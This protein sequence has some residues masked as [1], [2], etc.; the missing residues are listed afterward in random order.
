VEMD[1]E[2]LPRKVQVDS[3][4]TLKIINHSKDNLPELVTGQLLGL[5]NGEILEV[6]NSFPFPSLSNEQEDGED[7]ED[8]A[9][10][11]ASGKYQETMMRFLR[12]VNVDH[13]TVGWYCSTYLESFI[14]ESTIETQYKYQESIKKAVVLVYDP[15]KTSQ[16]VLSLKAYRLTQAFMELFKTQTFTKESLSKGN[17]TFNDVFEEVPI[18]IHNS[19]LAKAFLTEIEETNIMDCEFDRLNLSTNPFL[20]R[21]LEFLIDCLEGLASEQNKFQTYQRQVQRQQAQ[22][23]AWLNKRKQENTQ[24]KMI[25]KSPFQKKN[26]RYSSQSPNQVG[27]HQ[28]SQQIK[29]MII[30]TK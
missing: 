28:F 22:Q 30:A 1:D 21:N 23:Q 15:L 14:N 26:Q 13:D 17:M 29:L 4:V 8:E 9:K 18:E 19:G 7:G 10:H 20:E 3:L 16:G 27:S 25:V 12:E 11:E 5:D 24:R 2:E 6:T